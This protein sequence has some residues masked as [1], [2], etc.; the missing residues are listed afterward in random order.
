MPIQ[1]NY[2]VRLHAIVSCYRLHSLKRS[3]PI[4][5]TRSRRT[6]VICLFPY[7]HTSAPD[8]VRP[9]ITFNVLST[10]W[11]FCHDTF[12][13][14]DMKEDLVVC[15][16]VWNE[17]DPA[18]VSGLRVAFWNYYSE[19]RLHQ[20]VIICYV[21]LVNIIVRRFEILRAMSKSYTCK[22]LRSLSW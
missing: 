9:V 22:M 12:T 20:I 4:H 16:V 21:R 6:V 14:S 13:G 7:H 11:K 5:S 18:Y 1:Y 19:P 10:S 8:A 2:L 15:L 17:Q 3:R